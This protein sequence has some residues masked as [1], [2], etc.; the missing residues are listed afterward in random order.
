MLASCNSFLSTP[1]TSQADKLETAIATVST[2][3]AET[4]RARPAATSTPLPTNTPIPPTGT[5][6]PPSATPVSSFDICT[7]EIWVELPRGNLAV[8]QNIGPDS[9]HDIAGAQPI[10]GENVEPSSSTILVR[11]FTLPDHASNISG[12]I[13]FIADDGVTLFLNSEEVGNYD[14]QVWPPPVTF[15][16]TNLQPGTNQFRAEV[17]NRP[18]LAWFEACASIM[19]A[20]ATSD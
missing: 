1:T 3:L 5:A 12:T 6:L 18:S 4:Q 2:A 14:A 20:L 13:T 7:D 9:V 19:Y 17:Y 8:I 10:W 15:Q 16:L 11:S